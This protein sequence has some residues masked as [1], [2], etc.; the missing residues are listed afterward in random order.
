MLATLVLTAC[1]VGEPCDPASHVFD[2]KIMDVPAAG[3]TI[4]EPGVKRMAEE[5]FE[6][7]PGRYFAGWRC[8]MG[9]R[10]RAA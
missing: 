10:G 4:N 8:V 5:W 2:V 3:C 7:H 6:E 9:R 1:F